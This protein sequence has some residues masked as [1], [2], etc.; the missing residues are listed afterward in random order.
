MGVILYKLPLFLKEDKMKNENGSGSVYKLS[1][2]RRKCWVA[3]VTVG[4]GARWDFVPG[5]QKWV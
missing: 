2:K 4:F 1:G 3:R 5:K